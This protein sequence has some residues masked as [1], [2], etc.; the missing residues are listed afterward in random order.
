MALFKE[1]LLPG[2]ICLPVAF[3]FYYGLSF[4]GLLDSVTMESMHVLIRLVCVSAG[5]AVG[6]IVKRCIKTREVG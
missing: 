3:L 6:Y 1:I 5:F 4:L 2:T